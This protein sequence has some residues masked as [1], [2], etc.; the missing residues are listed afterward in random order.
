MIQNKGDE[1]CYDLTNIGLE[2]MQLV[3]NA[4]ECFFEI[5]ECFFPV[6]SIADF[7]IAGPNYHVYSDA[8]FIS[9]TP[10]QL[11]MIK[12]LLPF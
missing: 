8:L 7:R 2:G 11:E 1:Y 5:K 4:D 10:E 9:F 3:V 6:T 12:E